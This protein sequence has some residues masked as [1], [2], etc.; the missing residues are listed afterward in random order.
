MNARIAA[1]EAQLRDAELNLE[2]CRVTAPFSG[3]V[4][5]FNIS[6]GRVRAGGSGFIYSCGHAHLVCGR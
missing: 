6:T 4:V 1:A 5:N 3:K 2:Y